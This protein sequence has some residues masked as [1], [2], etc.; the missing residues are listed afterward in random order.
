MLAEWAAQIVSLLG[1]WL[2]SPFFAAFFGAL[3]VDILPAEAAGVAEGGFALE[4]LLGFVWD[5]HAN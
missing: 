2:K 5:L 3:V 4:A 1:F